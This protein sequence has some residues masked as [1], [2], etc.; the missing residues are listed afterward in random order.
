MTRSVT[1][2]QPVY[3]KDYRPPD[4]RIATTD[5][6]FEIAPDATLVTNQ[7]RL[8]RR[9]GS[10][11]S[12][13]RLDGQE[14]ELVSI[15]VDGAPLG[16]NEYQLDDDSLTLSGLPESCE[17]TVV[18]RIHPGSNTALEGLYESSG[19]YCTQCEAEGFRKITYY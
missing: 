6:R 3:L 13:V 11:A 10:D 4:Y 17:V 7:M 9:P 12:S 15:A 16:G 18:T 19:M 5:L 2:P 14:L 8:S 1:E